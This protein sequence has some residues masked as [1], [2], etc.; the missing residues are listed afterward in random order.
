MHPD[1]DD[2][3]KSRMETSARAEGLVASWL[4]RAGFYVLLTPEHDGQMAV[5]DMY[6]KA[7][8]GGKTLSVLEVKSRNLEFYSPESFPYPDVPLSTRGAYKPQA[9]YVIFSNVTDCAL[10]AMADKPRD[11]RMQGD[12]AR[13]VTGMSRTSDKV[14]LVTFVEFIEELW[15]R[16]NG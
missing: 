1:A 9:D 10:V 13:G 16:A 12:N 7:E 14:H 3:M 2:L 6:V 11:A 15:R 8:L 5:A 4:K